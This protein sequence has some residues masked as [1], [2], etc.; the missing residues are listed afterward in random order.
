MPSSSSHFNN[1]PH[2]ST[3]KQHVWMTADTVERTNKRQP[4]II[5]IAFSVQDYKEEKSNDDSERAKARLEWVF[6]ETRTASDIQA[7]QKHSNN[8]TESKRENENSAKIVTFKYLYL[9]FMA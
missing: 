4:I 3:Y 8:F 2:H 5:Y 6:I 1:Q 9:T 7:F